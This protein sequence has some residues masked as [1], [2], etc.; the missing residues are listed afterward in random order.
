[1]P[2]FSVEE[3]TEN[4]EHI[5]PHVVEPSFGVGRTVYTLLD[6]AYSEDTVDSEERTYLSLAP[7]I[8]PTDVAVFPLV[9]DDDLLATA[10]EVA[11]ELRAAGLAVSYD[12]S[13]SIGRRYRRQDEIGTPFCVTVDHDGWRATA[14]RR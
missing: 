14:S 9:G 1:L 6:H 7:E 3:Q 13:G 12:D 4:G 11:D 10:N 5:T 8:A 2:N